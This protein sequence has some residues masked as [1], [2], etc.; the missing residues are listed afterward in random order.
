MKYLIKFSKLIQLFSSQID[1][2]LY[3]FKLKAGRIQEL[4]IKRPEEEG[5][6]ICIFKEETK[7]KFVMP[8]VLGFIEGNFT[9]DYQEIA[10]WKFEGA[11]I[12][13]SSDVVVTR[14]G[15]AIWPKFFKYNYNH[16]ITLDKNTVFLPDGLSEHNNKLS[17]KHYRHVT[18]LDVV[19]SMIGVFDNIWAH[20]LV[21][22]VPKLGV[23]GMAIKDS[24]KKITVVVPEYKDE[25]L[26]EIVYTILDKYDVNIYQISKNEAIMANTLYFIERPTT[27]TDHETSVSVGDSTVPE[28]TAVFVKKEIV[29]PLQRDVKLNPQYKKIFLARRGGLGKGLI[30]GAEVE[31]FFEDLGFVFVEP[32]KLSLKE[33]V[34]MFMSAEY[35]AGPGGSAFT[36]LIFCR[37]G[38]KAIKFSNFQRQFE[39]LTCLSIQHFGVDV[40]YLTGRDDKSAKNLS[41]C[42]YYLPLDKVKKACEYHGII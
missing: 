1:Q 12:F 31:K 15:K 39:N 16:N 3:S 6:K 36:N 18:N 4:E 21:E 19:F 28:A 10:L 13:Y 22:Y 24:A 35:I 5:T 9:I 38:T 29:E 26:K 42:S 34:T 8:H 2:L 25:Q 11:K 33:K 27:F 30:N 40:I 37:P 17:V 32:H 20:A 41:H 14:N 7:E 23:L